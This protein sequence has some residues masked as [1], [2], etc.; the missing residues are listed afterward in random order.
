MRTF[1]ST[2]V[3]SVYRRRLTESQDRL[4]A[5]VTCPY[6]VSYWDDQR[7][8]K[9]LK[10]RQIRTLLATTNYSA[11]DISQI[12]NCAYFH[13]TAQRRKLRLPSEHDTLARRVVRLDQE[14]RDLRAIVHHLIG[15]QAV[16]PPHE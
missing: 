16:A 13:V 11:R 9:T 7:V 2:V 10:C 3:T 6:V 1:P 8:R 12:V 14:V 5:K 4:P 15:R